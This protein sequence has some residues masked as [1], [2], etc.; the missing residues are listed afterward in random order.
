[1]YPGRASIPLA[2]TQLPY[3]VCSALLL[4]WHAIS[5][6]TKHGGIDWLSWGRDCGDLGNRLAP[7]K[8]ADQLAGGSPLY[9]GAQMCFRFGQTDGRHLGL[10][11]K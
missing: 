10:L 11:T 2:V 6:A 7:P 8:D 5:H 4:D 3:E 9:Q 1:M